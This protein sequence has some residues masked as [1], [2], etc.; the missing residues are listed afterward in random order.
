MG[1]ERALLV[2]LANVSEVLT[3]TVSF[4]S[5]CNT[6]FVKG[7]IGWE[8]PHEHLARKLHVLA[9]PSFVVEHTPEGDRSA[10]R[11]MQ[12]ECTLIRSMDQHKEFTSKLEV[13]P[14]DLPT[15]R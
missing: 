2:Y 10:T 12:A 9:C 13:K 15:L 7:G 3:G 11:V 1:S 6:L 8:F 4:Q 14:F 5:F